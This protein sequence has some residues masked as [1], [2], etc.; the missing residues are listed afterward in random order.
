MSYN[1]K[2]RYEA[3][4][5]REHKGEFLDFIVR[6]EALIEKAMEY[7]S[8]GDPKM[9]DIVA[10]LQNIDKEVTEQADFAN[11]KRPP[12]YYAVKLTNIIKAYFSKVIE[13]EITRIQRG[14]SSEGMNEFWNFEIKNLENKIYF[15]KGAYPDLEVE[16]FLKKTQTLSTS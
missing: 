13:N 5:D 8:L 3:E 6:I 12:V 16:S 1:F 14:I 10:S 15:F 4:F 7:G 11:E 2:E 9:L